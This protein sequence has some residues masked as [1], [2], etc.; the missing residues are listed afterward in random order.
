MTKLPAGETL[1]AHIDRAVSNDDDVPLFEPPLPPPPNA[2]GTPRCFDDIKFAFHYG[3][4]VTEAERAYFSAALDFKPAEDKTD[5][6]KCADR[7]ARQR[8]FVKK[9][10]IKAIAARQAKAQ[11]WQNNT[12][13]AAIHIWNEKGRI[14]C[15]HTIKS[16]RRR[17]QYPKVNGKELSTETVRKFLAELRE[18]WAPPKR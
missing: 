4:P 16:L 2:D 6:A 17:E 5:C 13:L 9:A 1:Q 8:E 15:A 12:K 7:A 3:H 14:S 11:N 10:T 18:D